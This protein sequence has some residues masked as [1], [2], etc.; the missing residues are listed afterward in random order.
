MPIIRPTAPQWAGLGLV[1]LGGMAAARWISG[2]DF[3]ANAVPGFS[4]MG[5]VAPSLF[6]AAGITCL[7]LGRRR[8]TVMLSA[9]RLLLTACITLL[10]A[11]PSL[12]LIEHLTGISLGIDIAHDGAKPTA[13]SPFPG[14]MAPNTC[15][16]FLLAGIALSVQRRPLS[17]LRER[18]SLGLLLGTAGI[19]VA[20]CIGY[21]LRLEV[22]YTLSAANRMAL[23]TAYGLSLLAGALWLLRERWTVP[24]ALAFDRHEARITQRSIVVLAL[25][26]VFAGVG[27]FAVV[28]QSLEEAQ[29]ENLLLTATTNAESL[30]NTLEVSRWFPHTLATRPAVTQ[31]LARLTQ[32]P[33][34]AAARDFLLK[35]GQSFLT[36]G[37]DGIRFFNAA[38]ELVVVAGELPGRGGSAALALS[39]QQ[40]GAKLLWQDG[41]I[42][43]VE[44]AVTE[45]GR[46]VGRVVTEQRLPLF[47]RLLADIR[48]T[49]ASSDVLICSRVGDSASCAPTRFY[50][51]AFTVPMNDVD[52]R[53]TL[54]I[55]RALAGQTGAMLTKDLSG[56]SMLAAYTPVRPF[57]LGL[58]VKTDAHSLYASLRERVKLLAVL[59]VAL[60]GAGTLALR[61]QVRP[62]VA[63]VVHEQ[64]RMRVILENS[65]D[66]FIGLGENGAITDWNSEAQ[67][68][69]GWKPEEAIGR[70]LADLIIPEEHRQAHNAG[71]AGFRRT[72]T[73]PVVNRRIEVTALHRDGRRFTVELSVA[74]FLS[75]HGYVA[76]A[77]VRDITDRLAAQQQL[78]DSE[79][80]LR[81][82]S[83]SLPALISHLDRDERY[84]F[85]NRYFEPLLGLRPEDLVGKTL[86]ESRDADYYRQLQPHLAR[87]LKGESITFESRLPIHGELRHFQQNFVP[88]IGKSGDVLGFYSVTFDITD[89][90]RAEDRLRTSENRLQAITDNLPVL[91][92]CV[93]RNHRLT[94]ANQTFEDWTGIDHL[95]AVGKPLKEVLGPVLYEQRVAELDAALRGQR[96]EFELVSEALGVTRYLQKTYVPDVQPDGSVGGVYCLSSDVTSLKLAEQRLERLAR[97]DSLTGLPNRRQFED[98]LAQAMARSRRSKRPMA[99]I[100]L[101]VDHFKQINDTHGHGMGDA[102]LKE[103]A[104]RLEHCIRT[105]DTAARL[106]GDE[107][108]VILEGLNAV[109]EVTAV[110][111][112]LGGA[113]RQPMHFDGQTLRV[114]SSMG[115]AFF[116]GHGGS[117]DAI[118]ARADKALYRAKAA[119]RDTFAATTF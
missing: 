99:L 24:P 20:G 3:L 40:S 8:Q 11:F 38:N 19:G 36:A 95:T 70:N 25:V 109:E 52:G 118:I 49:G 35:V 91:I 81:G 65:N 66:A 101:D 39:P 55:N 94:F 53:L 17:R 92:S 86:A 2:F 10:V 76:N 26:V 111:A 93:D 41:Y 96:V 79:K 58:V 18:M 4:E 48:R 90:K 9:Q 67:R 87:V 1:W 61:S 57:G 88:D 44:E 59:L 5:I 84:Q 64:R 71:M 112:K 105:T 82:I 69:F 47:D 102:V 43:H 85:A 29:S 46:T 89:R 60:V 113:I 51:A 98:R 68:T 16:A 31:T 32:R 100:F 15:V 33:T 107:F 6:L 77:F 14:R 63:Q 45:Q 13:T 72:G 106:A 73:G 50:A 97:V 115:F 62:L 56:V 22:L 83:D 37:V 108:V 78:A 54:P 114:T 119:G 30:A 110:A 42:L 117:V 75:G 104:S 80:R 28:Q 74:A 21:L 103:F 7:L 34:D 23:P 116:E 27:G 12:M